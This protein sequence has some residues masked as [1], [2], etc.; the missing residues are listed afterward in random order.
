MTLRGEHPQYIVTFRQPSPENV[1]VL[2]EV[3]GQ[4]AAPR[5]AGITGD[6][7]GQVVLAQHLGVHARVYTR[8]AVASANLTPRELGT[9]EGHPLVAGVYLN[10]RRRL[11]RPV[12]EDPAED[13]RRAYLRGMRDTLSLL[14]DEPEDEWPRALRAR[15]PELAPALPG[16]LERS[17]VQIGLTPDY[18]LATGANVRVA[19]LDTGADLTHPDLRISAGN[20][21]SFVESEPSAQDENGHG[22]HCAG[23]IAGRAQP[24]GAGVARYGVAPDAE[25]LIGKVLN[26]NGEGFDDQILEGLAWAVELGADIISMS[27][28]SRRRP[29]EP[30]SSVYEDLAHT[31]LEQNILLIAA[32]GNESVRPRYVAP[33]GNPAACPSVLAVA[34]V[35]QRG[36]AAPFSCGDVDGVGEVDIA[37]PGVGILSAVPGG[38]ERLSGTSMA[39]PHVAGVAALRKELAPQLSARDLWRELTASARGL[40]QP[41]RDVGAGLVQVPRP[42]EAPA[43]PTPAAPTSPT[44]PQPIPPQGG[45]QG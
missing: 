39:T 29:G 28:G 27:L 8:L 6:G 26:K 16:A 40:A 13:V 33:V 34:A 41:P 30:F 14:L 43:A 18:A 15:L 10:E 12:R 2:S 1:S 17:L 21:R 36:A 25:L 31:L 5:Q 32:A 23:V 45:N 22:T 44:P 42:E 24:Q 19:V 35:D 4:P 3:T 20:S 11:P 37:A 38:Y 9:L 7:Q